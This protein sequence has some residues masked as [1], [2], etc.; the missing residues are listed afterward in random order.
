[1]DE[2]L[3]EIDVTVDEEYIS[4]V[5]ENLGESLATRYID[6]TRLKEMAQKAR[7]NRLI[8]E[9]TAAFFKKA[10]VKAGGKLR[11]RKDQFIAVDSLPYEIR[12]IG[13]DEK[14]KRQFGSL[15]R[16]YPKITFD[17]DIGFK[18]P[19][20]EFVT[21]GHPLFE[22]TLDWVERELT[23]ELQRG[24]VFTDP[25]GVL[26]GYI[27][28]YE[29]EVRDGTG[30]VAGK[31]LF[32]YYID[33][34][35]GEVKST[36]PTV[37]WDLSEV[38]SRESESVDSESLKRKILPGVISSLN[39]YMGRLQG[40]RKKQAEIKEK[41]GL[42]SLDKLVVGLDGDLIGLYARKDRGDNVDLA[43]RN[44]EDLKK[45]YEQSK[46]ELE[47]MIL[48]ERNLTMSMPSF[49]GI[50]SVR[51]SL[52]TGVA[53]H[54]D[55]EVERLGMEIAMRYERTQQRDPEDVS[56]ENLGFDIRSK[57]SKGK[58]RYV[59]VKA[60]A[61]IGPVALTQ[62]EWFK[63]QR[64]GTDYYLYA[65][66]NAVNDTK[67]KPKVIQDPAR[68]LKVEEKVEVVRY[69]VSA[70]EIEQKSQR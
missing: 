59:E 4:K 67:A 19:D 34:S 47:D 21:F 20:T 36:P 60:R 68:N 43:I 40:D 7:E 16:S 9:Y 17:K 49:L 38:G 50:V 31:S 26:N 57:D 66:W 12:Q 58:V 42:K 24:A 69:I 44:K 41:Y 5:K 64:L 56:K 53:M 55:E 33:S 39:E 13:E 23:V 30:V 27:L 15:L 18:T 65:V 62:N 61:G 54:R 52:D 51:P 45:K 8:P 6:Y 70:S 29:G 63:A 14:F 1:M 32:S 48:K 25:D 35:N 10:L 46:Q 3:K 22:A 37:I 11:D 28:F 2:I